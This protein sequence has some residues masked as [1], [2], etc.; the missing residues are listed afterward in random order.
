MAADW[1]YIILP[2]TAWDTLGYSP[3]YMG[4]EGLNASSFLRSGAHTGYPL[5]GKPD[6]PSGCFDGYKYGT[7]EPNCEIKSFIE[8]Y[9]RYR[10]GCDTS[11]GMSGGPFYDGAHR[12]LLGHAV[13][14]AC[15]TCAGETGLNF[16]APT[17]VL[18]HSED[19]FAF[20]NQLRSMYP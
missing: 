4:Y 14:E 10:V 3:A 7:T 19:M 6:S 9:W 16:Q 11:A 20:Q 17:Y 2:S 1:A 12:S 8:N 5:C 15:A 18:G 13:Y